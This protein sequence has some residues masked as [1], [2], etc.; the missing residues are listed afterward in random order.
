M[1]GRE[2]VGKENEPLFHVQLN[3]LF[4]L[5]FRV[6]LILPTFSCPFHVDILVLGR[7]GDV[8]TEA[9]AH[10]DWPQTQISAQPITLRALLSYTHAQTHTHAGT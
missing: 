10:L 9:H 1:G 4:R 3:H 5:A 7:P 2:G 6:V 8:F